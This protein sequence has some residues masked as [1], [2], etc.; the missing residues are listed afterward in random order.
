MHRAQ[1]AIHSVIP[2][3]K[4]KGVEKFENVLKGGVEEFHPEKEKISERGGT[5]RKGAL[6]Q[7]YSKK[8]FSRHL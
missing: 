6:T 4:G 8:W 2:P 3:C 7:S 1:K 5:I